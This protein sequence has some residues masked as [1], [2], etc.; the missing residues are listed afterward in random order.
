M[1]GYSR[2]SFYRFK[3]L[4]ETDVLATLFH[5]KT[6]SAPIVRHEGMDLSR[7][8][9]GWLSEFKFDHEQKIHVSALWLSHPC[10]ADLTIDY[11]KP[12]V[13]YGY[14]ARSGARDHS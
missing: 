4:Y 3:E 2:D 11:R 12:T 13:K 6:S 14:R 7:E 1:M 10:P 5:C 8:A 9:R